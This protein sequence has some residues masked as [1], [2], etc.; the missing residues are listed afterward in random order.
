MADLVRLYDFTAGTP[1]VADQVDAEFNQILARLNDVDADS[2]I[3][4][5]ADKLG[6][7]Q[8]GTVRRGKS[9]VATEEART[10]T[11][12]GTLTTP[13]RVQNVVLPADGLIVVAY[14]AMMKSSS[15]GAGR[16]A[17]FLDSNQLKIAMSKTAAPVTQAAPTVGT[18]EY[19]P[20]ATFA[21]GLVTADVSGGA[22][23]ADVTTGQAVGVALGNTGALLQELNG[24]LLTIVSVSSSTSTSLA[25][26]CV[27]FAAA[28][29]YDISVQFKA[30]AG[31][32]TAKER[33]LWVW[34]LGF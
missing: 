10:N 30:S 23:T 19:S 16:A 1:A 9:I 24:N 20:V 28:D 5:L 33:K 25:G 2:L 31:S 6:V 17:I 22:Y 21:G 27:I 14:Q 26:S 8:T 32:V 13:D 11:A 7:S 4:A 15:S 12:Y 3:S 18:N 34:T 29:T